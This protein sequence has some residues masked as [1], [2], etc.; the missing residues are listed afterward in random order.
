MRTVQN[1][2]TIS[3]KELADKLEF[4]CEKL[5]VCYKA[6]SELPYY[7]FLKK[8]EL[9][10]AIIYGFESNLEIKP[11]LTYES[12][13]IIDTLDKAIA[14]GKTIE[15]FERHEQHLIYNL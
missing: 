13:S 9:R 8:R 5:T 11:R 3:V 12:F 15:V 1:K 10:H 14:A 4:G 7:T 2:E 6:K